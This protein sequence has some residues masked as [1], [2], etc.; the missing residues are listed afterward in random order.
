MH[1]LRLSPAPALIACDPDPAGI[2]IALQAG[3]LWN[4]SGLTWHPWMMDSETLENLE[5]RQPLSEHDRERL[6]ALGE[7]ELPETL[8]DLLEWMLVHNEKGEQEGAL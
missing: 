3:E 2:E 5:Q 4:A 6:A 7:R 1:L 8:R